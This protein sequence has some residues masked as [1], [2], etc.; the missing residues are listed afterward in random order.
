MHAGNHPWLVL[1]LFVYIILYFF[2]YYLLHPN[3]PRSIHLFW[4]KGTSHLARGRRWTAPCRWFSEPTTHILHI[5]PQAPCPPIDEWRSHQVNDVVE[6]P[7]T[8][9]STPPF[10]TSI[11][12]AITVGPAWANP[13][14]YVSLFFPSFLYCYRSKCS[15]RFGG[16]CL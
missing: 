9:S 16:S 13:T 15:F 7:T 1:D 4:R 5:S 12:L 14:C 11:E 8:S 10:S 3:L 6:A 2:Y